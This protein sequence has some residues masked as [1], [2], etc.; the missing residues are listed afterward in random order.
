MVSQ[1]PHTPDPPPEDGDEPPKPT[2]PDAGGA[3]WR[4]WFAAVGPWFG[5]AAAIAAIVLRR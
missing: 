5:V 1:D 3:D 2:G 4:W